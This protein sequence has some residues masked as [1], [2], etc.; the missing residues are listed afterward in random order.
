MKYLKYIL[1]TL[2]VLFFLFITLGFITPSI[3]YSSEI[4]VDK[5]LKEAWAVMNDPD[6]TSEWLKDIKKK[7]IIGGKEG[8][9]GAMT[10]YTFGDANG[11]E[12]QI[13]ETIK[14]IDPFNYV[15]MDFV[16]EGAMTMHYKVNFEEKDGETVIKSAT[17]TEGDGMFMRSLMSFM[18][19]PMTEQEDQNLANLKKVIER[20]TKNY[21][22]MP[23]M[24]EKEEPMH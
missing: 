2:L 24:E 3:T 12:S 6:K 9:V 22:L 13:V 17:T 10:K 19:K 21:F 14:E 18:K 8:T 15:V 16:M 5:P 23:V 20:N 1:I 11:N 7:E 4:S